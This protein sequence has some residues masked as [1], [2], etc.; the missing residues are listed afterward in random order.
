MTN[1]P[2]TG[3]RTPAGKRRASFNAFRHGLTSK[4]HIHTPEESEAFRAHCQAYRA[5][6][7]PVGA[8]E[9]D[10]VQSIAE[11][12]WRLKRAR[13]IENNIFA[14]GINRHAGETAIR[15]PRNR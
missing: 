1:H 10:I 12:R 13:A 7:A 5:E 9:T 2:S 11:D 8:Q 6:L 4:V 15:R 14:E 3:P